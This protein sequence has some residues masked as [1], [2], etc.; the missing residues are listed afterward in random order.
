[1]TGTQAAEVLRLAEKYCAKILKRRPDDPTTQD[2]A[3][4][5]VD[6]CFRCFASFRPDKASLS[7]WV[8]MTCRS[9]CIDAYRKGKWLRSCEEEAE[10]TEIETMKSDNREEERL[11][12]VAN[13]FR[14][15]ATGFPSIVLM[16]VIVWQVS[17]QSA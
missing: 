1:M 14:Y 3:S 15:E 8:Y 9:I 6:R 7:T 17:S 16:R 10:T 4:D 12:G 13:T 11:I 5:V 2:R